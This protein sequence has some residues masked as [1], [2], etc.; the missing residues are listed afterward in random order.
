M[1]SL[2]TLNK[3]HSFSCPVDIYQFLGILLIFYCSLGTSNNPMA[4]VFKRLCAEVSC[5]KRL[6]AEV[7]CKKRLC[8]EVSCKK[9]LCAEVSCK[10]RLCAEVSCKKRLCA[11]VS[12][13]KRVCAEVSCK[14]P[15]LEKFAKLT[16]KRLS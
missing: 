8:A 11:E 6:C 15:Y 16:R 1:L 5:K 4:S 3:A 7:S 10:K 14:K 12:C 13:K 9:R 2:L